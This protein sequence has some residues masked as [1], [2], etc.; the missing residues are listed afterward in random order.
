MQH[1]RDDR[2]VPLVTAQ[3][4]LRRL[5]SA[6]AILGAILGAGCGGDETLTEEEYVAQLNAICED[7]RARETEIGEPR[8][9]ADLIAKGPRVLDAF[10][11]TILEEVRELEA[12]QKIADEAERLVALAEDQRVTLA[13]LIDAAKDGDVTRVRQLAAENQ[14]LNDRAGSITRALG[15]EGCATD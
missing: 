15:A 13:G 7:F 12:P 4:A 9:V 8:T 3:Q 14:A 5:A 11:E 6:L 2:D 10:E 1:G